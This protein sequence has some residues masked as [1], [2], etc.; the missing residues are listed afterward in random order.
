M[1]PEAHRFRMPGHSA[2]R[3]ILLVA[4]LFVAV[5][6]VWVAYLYVNVPQHVLDSAAYMC[7]GDYARAATAA[8]T[9]RIDAVRQPVSRLPRRV[10]PCGELRRSGRL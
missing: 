2:R 4:G 3:S 6:I 7:R 1:S 8:D 9:V 10:P 5:N